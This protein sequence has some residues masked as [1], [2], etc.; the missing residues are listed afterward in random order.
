MQAANAAGIA[1]AAGLGTGDSPTFT[2]VN[3]TKATIGAGVTK[4]NELTY[5]GAPAVAAYPFGLV[6]NL[7]LNGSTSV[8]GGEHGVAIAGVATDGATNDHAMY[9]VEGKVDAFGTANS[10]AAVGAVGTFRNATTFSG[11]LYGYTVAQLDITTNGTTPLLQ[12][13]AIGYFCPPIVGGANKFAFYGSNPLRL[14]G[15]AGTG[16]VTLEHD[17]TFAYI[18]ATSTFLLMRTGTTAFAPET[19]GSPLGHEALP[20]SLIATKVKKL[21]TAITYAATTN[22]DLDGATTDLQTLT[23]TGDVTFKTS[24]RVAGCEKKIVMVASGGTRTF[25][26]FPS[27]VWVG[28]T[29]PASLASGKTAVLTLTCIGTADKDIVAQ[30]AVQS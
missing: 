5:S 27:W 20:W 28:G 6:T 30:Y 1:T 12:G 19:A 4:A 3:A 7:T 24:N 9:G 11:T 8:S 2:G 14:T 25:T 29:A 16:G 17:G 18:G 23:L 10:Y 13:T 15:P 22:I 26:A 21:P